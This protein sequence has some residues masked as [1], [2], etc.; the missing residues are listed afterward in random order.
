MSTEV[1]V[2]GADI[3]HMV[4]FTVGKE[5]FGVDIMKVREIIR[6]VDITLIPNAP[7]FV[8]GIISLRGLVIPVIDFKKRFCIGDEGECKE[9]DRRIVVVVIRDRTIGLIVDKVTHVV[10]LDA[11]QISPPP[12]LLKEDNQDYIGGIGQVGDK[13]LIILNAEELVGK[14]ELVEIDQ[15]A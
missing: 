11:G 3:N 8:E 10:K 5:E 12:E 2:K 6:M 14:K 1:A 13:L 9:G 4:G 15:A 7:G